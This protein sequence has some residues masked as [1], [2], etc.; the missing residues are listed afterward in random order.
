MS[1]YIHNHST[2]SPQQRG[3]SE[4]DEVY[5]RKFSYSLGDAGEANEGIIDSGGMENK[6]TE[7]LQSPFT[8]VVYIAFLVSLY[9]ILCMTQLFSFGES[10]MITT[11][12]H[13]VITFIFF[14][15]IK[16]S[17]DEFTQG[18]WNGLT[19]WEQLDAGLPWTPTKKFLMLMPAALCLATLS[20]N[21]YSATSVAINVPVFLILELAKLP[22]MHRV[23]ILSINA[24]AGIDDH[25]KGQ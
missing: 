8:W 10:A 20:T 3:M 14:H 13:G 9:I 6:N 1:L 22:S 16:G 4:V 23:R 7:W 21:G 5:Q 2:I 19:L 17:P 11:V 15:W 12:A 25:I 18:E 24:T